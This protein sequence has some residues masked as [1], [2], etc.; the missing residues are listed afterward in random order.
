MN[1]IPL[2]PFSSDWIIRLPGLPFSEPL[3]VFCDENL[4]LRTAVILTMR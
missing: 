4:A 1:F 3:L 2:R